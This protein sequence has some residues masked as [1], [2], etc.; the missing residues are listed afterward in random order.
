MDKNKRKAE[1]MKRR[2]YRHRNRVRA[3]G[4]RPRLSVFRSAR[5]IAAQIIDD[6]AHSTLCAVTSVGKKTDVKGGGN[7]E[8]AKAIGRKIAELALQKGIKQVAFDRGPFKY[9]GRIKALADAA[10]EA[11]LEF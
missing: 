3:A 11:G 10:R 2:S 8:G 9:H 4:T 1:Q 5:H 7:I 6:K